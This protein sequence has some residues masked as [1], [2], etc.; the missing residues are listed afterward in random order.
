MV[1]GFVYSFIAVCI[2]LLGSIFWMMTA[3]LDEDRAYLVS[4]WLLL[5]TFFIVGPV[6]FAAGYWHHLRLHPREPRW[7]AE[8]GE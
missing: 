4:G 5:V 7:D 1:R 2:F 3:T 6:F 8:I